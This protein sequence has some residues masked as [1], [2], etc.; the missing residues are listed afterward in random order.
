[1]GS[2]KNKRTFSQDT[3]FA[4][5]ERADENEL[6]Q[7]IE[8]ATAN[9]VIDGLLRT[10]GGALAVLNEQRQILAA[11]DG[12]LKMLGSPG[13]GEVLGLRIGEA[14]RCTHA[15][16]FEGGCGTSKFCSTCEA[17]IAIVASLGADKTEERDCIVTVA[18]DVRPRDL[19]LRVRSC[20]IRL[21]SERFILLF[22]RDLTSH[23]RRVELE[24]VFFHDIGNL[25]MGLYGITD[26]LEDESPDRAGALAA[27]IR[28]AAERLGKEVA[29]Q[30][31]LVNEEIEVYPVEARDLSPAEVLGR[32][33]KAFAH[34][35]AAEDRSIVFPQAVP[36]RHVRTDPSLLLRI[37][38]NMLANALEATPEGG[39]VRIRVEEEAGGLS[40]RVWN[41][42]VIPKP[43]AQ[44]IFQRHFTTK[45]ESGR[46]LGTFAMRLLAEEYLG[47]TVDFSSSEHEGTVFRLWLPV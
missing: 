45:P 43:V 46:G 5:A 11:N 10:V 16:D 23:Q 19:Y 27:E 12:F 35:P 36:D 30:R 24:R 15:E 40:F 14:I 39:E 6:R 1:M 3:H 32:L 47:S 22:I 28:E 31:K 37:L 13:I 38:T 8:R 42:G 25:V 41:A 44:R 4:P 17:A 21:E 26:R 29:I 33:R 18:G 7:A 9:P 20:P 2:G 34:H